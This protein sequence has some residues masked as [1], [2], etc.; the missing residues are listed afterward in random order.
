MV[1]ACRVLVLVLFVGAIVGCGSAEPSRSSG[2]SSPGGAESVEDGGDVS[3]SPRKETVEGDSPEETPNGQPDAS[4]PGEPGAGT[5]SAKKSRGEG[6]EAF[7]SLPDENQWKSWGEALM[8]GSSEQRSSAAE[9]IAQC[10]DPLAPETVANLL[11]HESVHVRR[12]VAF[13]LLDR[14]DPNDPTVAAAMTEALSDEDATVRHIALSAVRRLP[15]S[16]QASAV[17]QLVTM[18]TPDREDAANRAA[19][20]RLVASLERQADAALPRLVEILREDPD[21]SVRSAAVA[22]IPRIAGPERAVTEL[23]EALVKESDPGVQGVL[24]VRLGKLGPAAAGAVDPLADKLKTND[25][26]LQRKVIDALI[27][28]GKP[29]VP[30]LIEALQAKDVPTRRL[31]VFAL[32]SLSAVAAEATEP[33]RACLNDDDEQVRQLAQV[34]LLR[35]Q[36]GR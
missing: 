30:R 19:I 31:A 5:S 23:S 24:V 26:E 10:L 17:V 11:T 16:S 13:Y 7:E 36:A 22:A 2:D 4:G 25:H 14:L 29:S 3:P 35:I 33:L 28:I 6:G 20:V 15:E 8:S 32:G 9:S 34:A 1:I 27:A 12:G 18:L 21:A